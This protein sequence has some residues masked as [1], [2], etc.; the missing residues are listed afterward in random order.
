MPKVSVK[1]QRNLIIP[2]IQT[3]PS[4]QNTLLE[5]QPKSKQQIDKDYYQKHKEKKKQ[6]RRLRYHQQKLQAQQ[7][8]AEQSAQYYEA[9][10]IKIL[11]SLK[12][13]TELN[14]SKH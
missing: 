1:T 11:M 9:E 13:Y 10:S 7:T 5:Y 2:Q 4:K 14:Q 6:Q 3:N 8:E 12:E